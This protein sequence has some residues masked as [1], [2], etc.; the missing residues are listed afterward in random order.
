MQGAAHLFL[1]AITIGLIIFSGSYLRW[2]PLL[3]LFVATLGFG[4][5]SQL[6]PMQLIA[7]V[8]S[9]FGSIMGSAGL[10]IVLGSVLGIILEETGCIYHLGNAIQNQFRANPSLGIA[11]LGYDFGHSCFLRCRI[12]SSGEPCKICFNCI[13][14][15]ASRYDIKFIRWL[16]HHTYAGAANTRTCGGSR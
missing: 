6:H 16:V 13:K 4:L 8:T 10:I 2:H 14:N 1:L 15:S 11:F 9:G 5:I 7:A 12:Y 3:S